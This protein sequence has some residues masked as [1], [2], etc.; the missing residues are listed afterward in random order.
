MYA[1]SSDVF[2]Y[3]RVSHILQIMTSLVQVKGFQK[4]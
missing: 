3:V 2:D 1:G 4:L